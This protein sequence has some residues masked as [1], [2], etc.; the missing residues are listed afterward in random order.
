M[1]INSA[2]HSSNVHPYLHMCKCNAAEC[3]LRGLCAHVFCTLK[4]PM[5]YIY[6][7]H[8]GKFCVKTRMLACDN[9]QAQ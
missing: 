3:Q 9:K 8:L 6:I 5:T 2:P 7:S 1:F 4:G